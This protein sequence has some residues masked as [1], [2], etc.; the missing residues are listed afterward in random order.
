MELLIQSFC[1]RMLDSA[2]RKI[3]YI[4]QDIMKPD[5]DSCLNRRSFLKKS[6]FSAGALAVAP[7]FDP[8]TQLLAN[9]NPAAVEKAIDL[10]GGIK[11][12]TQHKHKIMLKPNLVFDDPNCTTKPEVIKTLA[13]LMKSAGKDICIGEGSAAA[14][15]FNADQNGIYFTRN[16]ELLDKMQ[17]YVFD[18]L[19]YTDL[20]R[21]LDV[22]LINLHTGELVDVEISDAHY[23]KKLTIHRSL[24][25]IDMLCSLPMMKTHA[26]ATVT[27]GLK[28]VIG[29]YPGTAYCSV[30]SCVHEEA[31][32]AGSP[33]VAYEILDMVKA[34]KLGLTVIDGSMA[35]EG[36]G[37]SNGKLVKMDLIIAG[38][39]PLATDMV[40]AAT[41]GFDPGEIPTFSV[42][43]KSGMKPGS[44]DDIEIRGDKIDTVKRNFERAHVVPY[45]DIKKWFG[46]KE[47]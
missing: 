25:D 9:S 22:P 42:A 10:L 26:L 3:H 20:A 39:N 5:K 30:R 37:P 38:C 23:F 47:V 43:H 4:N 21:E 29:L 1:L 18:K 8:Y 7:F 19:G 12:V 14:S 34:N 16:S 28:N 11:H 31:E 36:E 45:H 13:L 40:A 35:M 33:G 15:G 44:L 27:L 32:M 17:Q 6:M 41:M 24:R 2:C 46:A